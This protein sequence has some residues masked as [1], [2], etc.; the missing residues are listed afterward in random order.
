MSLVLAYQM[1]HTIRLSYQQALIVHWLAHYSALKS[2]QSIWN[3]CSKQFTL[4]GYFSCNYNDKIL[5]NRE[6]YL[7]KYPINVN[8]LLQAFHIDW[9]LFIDEF[10]DQSM[11]VE[12]LLI[13]Q[14]DSMWLCVSLVRE[15]SLFVNKINCSLFTNKKVTNNCSSNSTILDPNC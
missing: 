14:S 4:I 7:E 3:A 6:L 9:A 13:W 5:T 2:A 8:C 12:C 1:S 15:Y 10:L 11:N